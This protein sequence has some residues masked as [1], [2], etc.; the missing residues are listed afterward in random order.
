MKF[1]KKTLSYLG[2]AIANLT[3]LF[4]PQ[5]THAVER[6]R[7]VICRGNHSAESIARLCLQEE[8]E[9]FYRQG[10]TSYQEGE[11][12]AAETALQKSLEIRQKILPS[13]HPDLAASIDGVQKRFTESEQLHLQAL[14]IRER[15]LGKRH[16]EVAVSLDGLAWL[17]QEQERF[18]EAIAAIERALDIYGSLRGVSGF[19]RVHLTY[20]LGTIYHQQGKTDQA[21]AKYEEAFAM[22]DYYYPSLVNLGLLAYENS[23]REAA[24]NYWQQALAIDEAAIEPKLA[25]AVALYQEGKIDEALRMGK[26]AIVQNQDFSQPEFLVRNLWGS[27]LV[28]AAQLFFAEPQ[29]QKITK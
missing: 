3:Y 20:Q 27:E 9:N 22:D 23:D 15:R 7:Q 1:P 8:A 11:Y 21:I 12:I 5:I 25:L 14:K 10:I 16:P 13:N 4:V 2:V 29:I 28:A 24:I 26:T 18:D 19:N 6:D 17:Y